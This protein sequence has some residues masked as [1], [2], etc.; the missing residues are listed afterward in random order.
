[1]SLDGLCDEDEVLCDDG[2][3]CLLEEMRCNGIVECPGEG[4]ADE[5]DCP[6]KS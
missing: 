4:G 2:R 6:C 5:R 1:L 3:T